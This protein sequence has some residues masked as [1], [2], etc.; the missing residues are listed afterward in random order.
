EIVETGKKRIGFLGL[1]FKAGTDDLRESPLVILPEMLLG[2]GFAL[3]IYDR[4]VTLARLVG[5]NKQYIEQQ[6]PHL[7][8]LLV[9]TSDEIVLDSEVLVIGTRSPEFA[10]ALPRC[11]PEQIVIDLVGL[12]IYA[13]LLRADYRGLCW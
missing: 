1:S 4:N 6:I 2:K 8:S 7:S 12:P 3:R 5:A 10:E 9:G 13:A 11:R